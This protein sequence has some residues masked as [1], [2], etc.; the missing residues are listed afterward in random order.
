MSDGDPSL[1]EDIPKPLLAKAVEENVFTP[2]IATPIYAGG[3][4]LH[5]KRTST[6]ETES[7]LSEE[8]RNDLAFSQLF[9]NGNEGENFHQTERETEEKMGDL[10]A[11]SVLSNYQD[12]LSQDMNTDRDNGSEA[13]TRAAEECGCGIPDGADLP[14]G[15][16]KPTPNHCSI[17][18][19]GVMNNPSLLFN[20][21]VRSIDYVL[22]WESLKEDGNKP[23]AHKHRRIFEE[24]LEAEG[25]HEILKLRMPMKFSALKDVGEKTNSMF[26][27]IDATWQHVMSKLKVDPEQFPERKH[28]LTAIY[29]KDKEYLVISKNP[30]Q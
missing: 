1:E 23:E 10:H 21:G 4:K 6:G 5:H 18:M 17:I 8:Q 16:G 26:D 7:F 27:K 13:S 28:R 12:N 2:K 30:A 3:V 25:L 20:D 11:M 15:N 24:N 22:V 9:S 19:G 14:K 29:S